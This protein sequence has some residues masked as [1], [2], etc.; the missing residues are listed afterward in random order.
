[1]KSKKQQEDNTRRDFLRK[2]ITAGIG[3][4][5]AGTMLS[6]CSK[7]DETTGEKVKVLTTDGKIVEVDRGLLKTTKEVEQEA[8]EGIPG[9]KFVMVIDLAKCTNAR[10]CVDACQEGHHL[11]SNYEYIKVYLMQDAKESAPYWFPRP[12]FHCDNPLCVSVCP[13]GATFKRTDGIVLVDKDKCIGC[14]FCMTGCPYSARVFAWEHHEEYD[15]PVKYNPET[16]VPGKEGTVSK[17]V[18][19]ADRLRE[20]KLPLCAEACPMGVIYF[21]D[22]NEDT[23]TNGAETVSFSELIRDR[24]GY[25]HMESLGTRPSVYYLPPVNRQFPLERGY[26]DLDEDNKARYDNTPYVKKRNDEQGK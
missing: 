17:C 9:R 18:F 4:I 19:C 15:T 6:S 21:G 7:A 1:M 8:R 10:K 12:C 24:A 14:K 13:V 23:V 20:N 3:A 26:D 2:G 16:T 11:P 25:R 5:A 22:I